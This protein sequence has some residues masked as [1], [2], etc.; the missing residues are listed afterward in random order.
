MSIDV[1]ELLTRAA[2]KPASELDV[3]ALVRTARRRRRVRAACVGAAV[4]AAV[5]VV[6]SLPGADRGGI[7]T[8]ARPVPTAVPTTI[9]DVGTT[10]A[11][12]VTPSTGLRDRQLVRVSGRFAPPIAAEEDIRVQTCRVG[13]T[14]LTAGND[15]D[16]TTT[17]SSSIVKW[18]TLPLRRYPYMVRRRITIG[19]QERPVDCAAAPGCVLYAAS[20]GHLHGSTQSRY[21]QKWGVAPLAFDATASPRPGPTVTVTPHHGLRDG[22]TVTVRAHHF[23]P[24]GGVSVT[25]CVK[26]TDV[27]DR[28]W[29]QDAAVHVPQQRIGR[30][31][32]R[33]LTHGV[34]PVFSSNARLHDCRSVACV[35]RFGPTDGSIDVPISFSPRKRAASSPR[36]NLDP[37]GPYSDGQQVTVT[38]N[39]WPGSIGHR[40][41]LAIE[42]L[43]VGQC[44]SGPYCVGETSLRREL[45]GRYTATLTLHDASPVEFGTTDC[46]QPGNCQV[47]LVGGPGENG[48]PPLVILGVAV[49]VT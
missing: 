11:I 39:G 18:R 23:R 37:A 27:C 30:N 34:W 33:S 3:A 48:R 38:L 40:P 29:Y 12:V 17:Q 24:F 45:D 6:V 36:L 44:G 35:V 10:H 21:Q 1:R 31:G 47:A 46:S 26:G 42:H 15:C 4:V 16:G 7:Q 13:V 49:V 14:P 32:S 41:D 43:T 22:D 25:V 8:P 28:A 2:A 9:P 20:R 19:F 5:V